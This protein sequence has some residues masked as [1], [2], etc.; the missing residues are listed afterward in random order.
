[1]RLTTCRHLYLVLLLLALFPATSRAIPA[2]TCHCF[3]ERAYDP[4]RPS[5]ADPYL[6]ATTQNSFLA[7][8]FTVEKK[9]IVL[10]KQAGADADDL[11]IAYWLAA[12]TGRNVEKL[13][14]ERKGKGTWRQVVASLAIVDNTPGARVAAAFKKNAPDEELA[15]AVVDELLL[16]FRFHG[17]TEL[18][19]L[20]QA[21]ASHQEKILAGLIAAKSRQPA[22]RIYRQ[23]KEGK[24]SW[25]ELLQRAQIPASEIQAVITALVTADNSSAGK[26]SSPPF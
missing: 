1:M 26:R 19:Q 7:A 16:R 6:L 15:R 17:E 10:K 22:T 12:K 14:Q 2:I 20:Q 8:A 23:V 24:A 5:G 11:W 9:T 13:L 18:S 25:G 21:G 3:T 4:A